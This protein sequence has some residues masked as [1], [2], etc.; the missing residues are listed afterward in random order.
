MTDMYF[1]K[2]PE[3]VVKLSILKQL[4]SK[5]EAVIK[6]AGLGEDCA[7]F[8]FNRKLRTER[9]FNSQAEKQPA[10]CGEAADGTAMDSNIDAHML[11]AC[12]Q[13]AAVAVKADIGKCDAHRQTMDTLILKC[14]NNLA[15]GGAE[16]VAAMITLL[17][18]EDTDTDLIR[19]LMSEADEACGRYGMQI[20]GGQTKVMKEVNAPVA[21]INAYGE[22]CEGD[23]RTAAMAKPGQDIVLSK[24]AALQGTAV[25]AT[26]K[27]EQ[28]GQHYPSYLAEEAA[29]FDRYLSIAEEAKTALK[30]GV[31]AMH[32]ASEGGILAALWEL[33]EAAGVG[34]DIDIKK[35]PLRQETVEICECVGVNPYEL[36][37]GGCL[38]MTA[39]DGERLV[40]ALKD[41]NIPAVVIGRTTSEKARI[42]RNEDEVRYMD[43]PK[44]DE[45]YKSI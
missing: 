1:G 25:I 43:R 4:H 23:F 17:L 34:L 20:A 29:A 15:V 13:E 7:L 10:E 31:C 27:A 30:N 40:K 39:D 18:P 14:V 38:V 12:V 16:P 2:M 33:A 28:I 37:S 26:H 11:A 45:I 42:I 41:E 44:Q 24:W 22:T 3:N 5:N 8:S 19:T 21:V 6:G 9:R 36:L 35:I 32:D